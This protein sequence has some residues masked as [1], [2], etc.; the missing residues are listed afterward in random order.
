[1]KLEHFKLTVDRLAQ[2]AGAAPDD[3]LHILDNPEWGDVD[4]VLVRGGVPHVKCERVGHTLRSMGVDDAHTEGL[5]P[6][7]WSLNRVLCCL[8]GTADTRVRVV[9]GSLVIGRCWVPPEAPEA[10]EAVETDGLNAPPHYTAHPS[11]VECITITE[12]MNFNKGSAIK[13][14]WR[15]GLKGSE[16]K[17]LKKARFYIDREIK[18]LEGAPCLKN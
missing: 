14:V 9:D 1:M 7:L 11:G 16:V 8:E 2:G 15:S 12:H 10:P 3:R 18:R 4:M 5:S 6:G 13:Y 17:D